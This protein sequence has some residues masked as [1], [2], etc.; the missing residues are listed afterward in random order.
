MTNTE[1]GYR[2]IKVIRHSV[3]YEYGPF[4]NENLELL[5]SFLWHVIIFVTCDMFQI[6][7]LRTR[8]QC[9]RV[10]IPGNCYILDHDKIVTTRKWNIDRTYL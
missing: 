8:F 2:I 6:V 7:F 9:Q 4:A 10:P 1:Y 5:H 3:K